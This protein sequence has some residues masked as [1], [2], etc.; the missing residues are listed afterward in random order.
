MVEENEPEIMDGQSATEEDVIS[1]DM[2]N[3]IPAVI[4]DDHDVCS[5]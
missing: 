3:V 5:C 4:D 2:T 1:P